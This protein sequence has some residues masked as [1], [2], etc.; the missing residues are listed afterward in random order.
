MPAQVAKNLSMPTMSKRPRPI[1][2]T[3]SSKHVRSKFFHR[4][5]ILR[6]M[7]K[8]PNVPVVER[9]VRD[10]RNV[11]V[12]NEPLH[13]SY[14]HNGMKDQGRTQQEPKKKKRVEFDET[15]TVVPIP[16]RCE[17]SG[18]IKTK[19]WNGNSE[20]RETV[21]RN[22]AEFAAENYNWRGACQEEEMYICGDTR[23]LIHPV[24]LEMGHYTFGTGGS[25]RR[26]YEC[27][28]W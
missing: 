24:H 6:P 13:Y 21:V 5:G 15:V 25:C 16:M 3:S 22:L 20:I 18:R 9:S 11:P 26:S 4:I 19:L 7:N 2:Y 12:M 10:L 28:N 8:A 17:Y 14:N 1:T 23:E 27:G